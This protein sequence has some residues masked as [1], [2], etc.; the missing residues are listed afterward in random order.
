MTIRKGRTRRSWSVQFH[1]AGVYAQDDWNV[2]DR[3]K[4]TYGVRID[5]LFFDNGDLMT[6]NAILEKTYYP[7]AYNYEA[8]HIDT[9]KWPTAK[10]TFS[11]RVG[12][13]WDVFGDKS[14]KVR[15]G[16]GLFSG[17]LPLVFFTNMPTNGGLV[18]YQAQIGPSTRYANL[19]DAVK[20]KYSNVNEILAQF[21]GGMVTE[22][23]QA[24][25]AA[26]YNKLVGMGFPSTV[27]PTKRN[28]GLRSGR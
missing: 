5:G 27:R 20:A 22:N 7:R 25:V 21:A 11:P 10:V 23:G 13:S 24:N 6:N 15:G 17:R 12:F 26:L 18:Q 28:R 9:G 4:L 2:T 3:F 8:T 1:K 14:F 16:T 19:P